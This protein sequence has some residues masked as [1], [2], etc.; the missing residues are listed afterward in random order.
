MVTCPLCGGRGFWNLLDTDGSI[1]E[2]YQCDECERG[3]VTEK[4]RE[5][6]NIR[7]E[8]LRK[9]MLDTVKNWM[10]RN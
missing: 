8:R 5:E 9:S 3:M 1:I 2:T 6:M 4:K 10:R 7:A